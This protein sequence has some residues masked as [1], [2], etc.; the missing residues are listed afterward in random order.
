M[1][2]N[3]E[4]IDWGGLGKEF[5]KKY[6]KKSSR[7]ALVSD[8]NRIVD[9]FKEIKDDRQIHEINKIDI[10]KNIEMHINKESNALK[11][12]NSVYKYIGRWNDFLEFLRTDKNYTHTHVFIDSINNVKEFK[13]YINKKYDLKNKE[14][15]QSY[16]VN[17]IMEVLRVIDQKIVNREVTPNQRYRLLE[18]SIYIQ[19]T[20]LTGLPRR[21]FRIIKISDINC[22]TGVIKVKNQ[23][24][25]IP[26]GT[27]EYLKEYL[28]IREDSVGHGYLF[29]KPNGD[30]M[31]TDNDM[32]TLVNTN[33]TL[34]NIFREVDILDEDENGYSAVALRNTAILEMIKTKED[35]YYI[36]KL[37]G[38]NDKLISELDNL[39]LQI[40]TSEQEK[41]LAMKKNINILIQ[42]LPYYDKLNNDENFFKI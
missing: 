8:I 14:A 5:L 22:D 17:Q 9:F 32:A 31:E 29:T 12:Q 4:K 23:E 36:I 37:S 1:R 26:R 19:L 20:L 24:I 11:S 7:K 30:S 10:E 38:I 18:Q 40:F 33:D 3:D 39:Y 6:P 34:M 28:G 2:I 25:N 15:Q 27:M 42:R 21:D 13:E 16:D 41:K 35:L